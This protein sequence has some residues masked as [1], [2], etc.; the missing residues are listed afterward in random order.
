MGAV[1]PLRWT[2]RRGV[3][4]VTPFP[5]DVRTDQLLLKKHSLALCFGWRSQGNCADSPESRACR[6]VV[7]LAAASAGKAFS[8]DLQPNAPRGGTV[9][10]WSAAPPSE[11]DGSIALTQWGF[12]DLRRN[13]ASGM[14]RL[15]VDLLVIERCLNHVS[16]ASAG[17]AASIKDISLKT[18]CG[19]R[20]THAHV[21]ALMTGK[22][23]SSV[24][25]LAA[26]R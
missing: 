20:C 1:S 15:G 9:A 23:T 18:P 17:S 3:P 19:A 7:G 21:D 25:E 16:E 22:P 8:P 24:V 6:R 13:C 11:A 14:A 12:H 2:V 5:H 4:P 26:R 10:G